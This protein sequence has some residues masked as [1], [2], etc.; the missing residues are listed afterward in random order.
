MSNLFS[1]DAYLRNATEWDTTWEADPPTG[2]YMGEAR[3]II[4]IKN[5]K[6]RYGGI[7]TQVEYNDPNTWTPERRRTSC[8]PLLREAA[9]GLRL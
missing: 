8:A 5:V 9:L 6:D 3:A 7:V 1:P 2:P 4:N